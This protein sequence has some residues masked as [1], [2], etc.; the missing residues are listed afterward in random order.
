MEYG[1][2]R[3]TE[4]IWRLKVP[5]DTVYTSVFLV[6]TDE[7]RILVD[8]A[9][10]REDVDLRIAPACRALGYDLGEIDVLVLTHWHDDHAGGKTR[11]LE[12]APSIEIVTDVREL[13]AEI[14]TY[15][16]AGHTE[17][18]IGV[19]DMRT[20]TLIS[21]D[22]LQGAGVDKYRATFENRA[23]YR[24]TLVRLEAEEKVES[25]LFSHAYEPWLCDRIEGRANVLSCL[26]ECEKYV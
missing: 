18:C 10:T 26:R 4:G 16:M 23:A 9:T 15:P 21:G 1:F 3:E 13:T 22:G 19:L 12:L 8:C 11:I 6:V 14:A 20:R 7:K 5:F 2:Y 17:G 24:Q 25:I